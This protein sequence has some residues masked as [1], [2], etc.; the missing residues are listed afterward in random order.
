MF[1]LTAHL[2]D[3]ITQVD[4]EK[5]RRVIS[6]R[7]LDKCTRQLPVLPAT[8]FDVRQCSSHVAR[9]I[10]TTFTVYPTVRVASTLVAYRH[11][12]VMQFIFQLQHIEYEKISASQQRQQPTSRGL[13]VSS[14]WLKMYHVHTGLTPRLAQ[15]V[16]LGVGYQSK[17]PIDYLVYS[18]LEHLGAVSLKDDKLCWSVVESIH[19]TGW[20]RDFH[21]RRGQVDKV[22]SVGQATPTICDSKF[23]QSAN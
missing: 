4:R 10:D 3:V 1:T 8:A 18:R 16:D 9:V 19:C 20:S 22:L 5:I 7:H 17:V 15:P 11:A 13:K 21:T 12:K 6:L 14:Y 2:Y 23:A